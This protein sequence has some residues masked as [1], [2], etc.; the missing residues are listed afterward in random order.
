MRQTVLHALA[1]STISPS[2]LLVVF[3][4]PAWESS[5]WRTHSILLHPNTTILAHLQANQLK[6]I[7][8]HKQLDADLDISLL[9]PANWLVDIVIVAN[10]A[11]RKSYLHHD[12][13]QHTLIPGILQSCQD[14]TQTVTLFPT[15]IL[16]TQTPLLTL[17]PTPRHLLP[18]P[19]RAPNSTCNHIQQ[20]LPTPNTWNNHN[21]EYPIN[22]SP[23]PT[24]F[25]STLTLRNLAL[26]TI[27]KHP[28]IILEL[29][30][31]STARI[32]ALLK[33][34]HRIQTYTWADTNSDAHTA[35]QHRLTQLHHQYPTQLPLAAI[36]QWDNILP[37][38]PT[39]ITPNIVIANL[40]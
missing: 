1:S 17:P 27:P 15:T 4:L 7:P 28:L 20:P 19:R 25:P 10:E 13:L 3:I 31:G 37:L 9:R 34:G 24:P 39:L 30:S 18:R 2:P 32:E 5:P 23:P 38:K 29:Y 40:S 14:P 22:T 33:T 16:P 26:Y 11:G 12:S 21:V 36:N 8:T 6:F 35:I